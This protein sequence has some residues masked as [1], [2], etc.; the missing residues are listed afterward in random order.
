MTYIKAP[1]NFVPLSQK[2]F[3][4]DWA[5]KVSHDIPFENGLS[6][7]IEIKITAI[8]PVFVRNG[9]T[10]E[11]AA[12]K[13][14]TF[15]SFSNVGDEYFIPSTSI[16][17]ML[18]NVVEI[19]SFGKMP[20]DKRKRYAAR[21][22][23][24]PDLNL[25]SRQ[26]E[27]N[28]G[29]LCQE[30]GKLIIKDCGKPYRI[31]HKRIDEFLRDSIFE[32]NF[33]KALGI[34]LNNTAL[35]D[36]KQYDPKTASYKYALL[37]DIVRLENVNIVEDEECN[38]DRQKN[39]VKCTNGNGN[40]K[41][42][43]VLT[44][45]PDKWVF[46]RRP[47]GG[48]FY[49]FVFHDE[50]LEKIDLCRD[51]FEQVSFFYQDS[52][53]WKFWIKKFYKGG[54]IPVFF[55]KNKD[56]KI[57]DFGLA[58]MYKLPY[59]NSVEELVSKHQKP[60][61]TDLAEC[62]FGYTSKDKSLR[63]RVQISHAFAEGEVKTE[64]EQITTLGSPKASYYPNYIKQDGNNGKVQKYKTYNDG[65]ISGWK[66]YPVHNKVIPRP[67]ENDKM[68][69]E[70]I[71]LSP[72]NEF[73]CKLRY[74]NLKPVELGALLSSITFHG[75]KGYYHNIG[76]AK[77][78]GY[79]KIKV[80]LVDFKE[81][82][83]NEYLSLFEDAMNTLIAQSKEDAWRTSPQV[84]EL[85]AMAREIPEETNILQYM[86]MGM[87]KEVNEFIEAKN[88]KE[89]LQ[90][91]SE[92]TKFNK[93]VESPLKERN[94]KIHAEAERLKKEKEDEDEQRKAR[95]AKEAAIREKNEREERNRQIA[96]AGLSFLDKLN[97][98]DQAKKQ[99]DQYLKKAGQSLIPAEEHDKLFSFITNFYKNAS[100]RDKKQW[101][102]PFSESAPWKKIASWVGNEQASGWYAKIIKN[103]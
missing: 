43:V 35:I 7:T 44:G 78:L 79:G 98:F 9:Y 58:F 34:N 82:T 27:I 81:E 42:T 19:I 41:G 86:Q 88:N 36:G 66:R 103:Q 90:P 65:E 77:P 5:D 49:E 60:E 48:K 53:D 15:K 18:R 92:I 4:P 87:E 54:R 31:N 73:M 32:K 25:K 94:K 61:G 91:Y 84:G 97:H 74:H 56:G 95:E 102:Q 64:E 45:Q 10:R 57:K 83:F 63:S 16:K 99:I 52:D 21:D 76:M 72:G 26:A 71:P 47:G 3:Y 50:V 67:T 8:T 11:D 1:Y 80:D 89:Y 51:Y 20:V 46:P 70:F 93:P 2:V 14:I 39:R 33:S 6:G 101:N 62:I 59:E 23:S 40:F 69:T 100:Q 29:W 38:N 37:N 17:G 24:N 85:F 28:C 68:D 13:S 12:N 75:N 55:R 22:W 96:K 30:N